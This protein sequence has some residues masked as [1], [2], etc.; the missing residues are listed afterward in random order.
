RASDRAG[1]AS[2]VLFAALVLAAAV[3][4]VITRQL[5]GSLGV[6]RRTAL[7][8]AERDLPRAVATIRDGGL[9]DTT[10]RPVPVHTT[11]DVGQLA[12][13]F[14][15]VHLQALR[16]AADEAILRSGYGSLFVDLSR[17]SQGL[18]QRQLQLLERLERDEEDPDQLAT[19]FQLDHLATRMRRNN[20]NLMVLSGSGEQS[21]RAGEPLSVVDLLRAA[22]SEIEHY[23]RVELRPPPD[24]EVAS[25]A[26]GDLVRLVAELLDNATAFSPPDTTV[27]V[28][29]HRSESGALMINVID[30]GIGMD[31]DAVADVNRRL[32]ATGPTDLPESRRMGLFVVGRLAARNGIAVRLHAGR[33]LQGT[34]ATVTVPAELVQ[35]PAPARPTPGFPP[36]PGVP[37]PVNGR[38]AVASL[39]PAELP[40]RRPNGHGMPPETA[41][42]ITMDVPVRAFADG[43]PG[44]DLP[45]EVSLDLPDHVPADW[46]AALAADATGHDV[47][48]DEPGT[49]GGTA[50][51]AP[52][53]GA[54]GE[55][56]AGR[57]AGEVPEGMANAVDAA[58]E[59]AAIG[60]RD[61]NTVADPDEAPRAREAP[62]TKDAPPGDDAGDRTAAVNPAAVNP[63]V[64]AGPADAVNPADAADP[65]GVPDQDDVAEAE[66]GNAAG[67]RDRADVPPRAGSAPGHPEAAESRAAASAVAGR[68]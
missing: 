43:A 2:V 21:R 53:A 67:A 41:A 18:V 9:P 50:G 66:A 39:P 28:A 17:R 16:L 65:P 59:P 46:A 7:D 22:I 11:E 61:T 45:P 42:E 10:V 62:P 26:A 40:H 54:A 5:L 47:V 44:E 49:S 23:R 34:Q 32:A 4:A 14:D 35:H 27:A 58:E 33:D 1:L 6:L 63:A 51:P 36:Q 24:L 8:V 25:R 13:A 3:G 12:R 30:H 29:A 60:A 57:S 48:E 15:A 56:P 20:E 31:D 64:A 68:P 37:S 38:P 19:L 55:V 52:Q